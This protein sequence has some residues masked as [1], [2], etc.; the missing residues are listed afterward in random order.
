M[1][2]KAEPYHFP[3]AEELILEEEEAAS[4]ESP[5]PPPEGDGGEEVPAVDIR[6]GEEAEAP[7]PEPE[8]EPEPDPVS[9]AQIQA[10][11]IIADAHRRAE[12]IL[13][14]ARRES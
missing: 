6:V 12:E 2:P 9:F 4:A 8:P 5:P 10:E 14:Q 13:D 11:Q 3:K 7:E 1:R